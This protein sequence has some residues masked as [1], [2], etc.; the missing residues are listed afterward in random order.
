[1]NVELK[2]NNCRV[3]DSSLSHSTY[4]RGEETGNK[5]EFHKCNSCGSYF[6]KME[7]NQQTENDFYGSSTDVYM[8]QNYVQNRVGDILSHSFKNGWLLEKDIDFLDIGCG[9]GWSLVTS[10]SYGFNA[11]GI[12]P[13]EAAAEYANK[14]LNVNVTNSLFS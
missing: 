12:E 3:C 10:K 13:M 2:L 8:N 14:N 5:T 4:I 11:Y 6:S 1:M 7:F 9:L